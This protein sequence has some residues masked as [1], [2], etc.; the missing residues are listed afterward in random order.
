MKNEWKARD[1]PG[2]KRR[3]NGQCRTTMKGRNLYIGKTACHSS[4]KLITNCVK[5]LLGN[6]PSTCLYCT[7]PEIRQ[8]I[9]HALRSHIRTILLG[10]LCWIQ[11]FGVLFVSDGMNIVVWL[12]FR[13]PTVWHCLHRSFSSHQ[14]PQDHL[15]LDPI[16]H[17]QSLYEEAT[18]HDLKTI[19]LIGDCVSC[20]FDWWHWSCTLLSLQSEKCHG[21]PVQAQ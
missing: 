12:L 21:L 2:D 3:K 1:P 8:L 4:T 14:T 15:Y 20:D 13:S 18:S 9:W 16:Q 19:D 6:P 10:V 11:Q 7:L 5:S 17:D